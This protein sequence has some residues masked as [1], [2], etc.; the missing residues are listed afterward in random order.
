MT[1][2]DS[3]RSLLVWHVHGSWTESFVAGRHR[4]VVPVNSAQDADGRGLA[5]RNWPRAQEVPVEALHDEDIDL[6]ILQRPQELDL[7]ERWLG[8][9]PG[10]DVPAVYVE[11]NAPRPLPVDSTHPVAARSDIPVVHVTDFNRLMWDS[12]AAPTRVITHGIADPG[13]LY[14][15]DV[16]AAASMINE[17]LRRWRTVGTDVLIE[18]GAHVP[19][20]VWGID[21]LELGRR[22]LRGVRP[23]GDVPTRRLLRQVARR[24]VYLHTARWTSLGMSL[25][26]AMYLGLP[27]VAVASTMAPLVV[28]AEAGLVSADVGTLANSIRRFVSDRAA[29]TL[30]G[31]AA[32]EYAIAH[33]S[34][35]RF[36]AE[37]GEVIEQ[38]CA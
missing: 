20:D 14:T 21:T 29:A 3:A 13:Y 19:I 1:V 2:G 11:H 17:P 16:A 26:E 8:R 4:Y 28:P 6:V 12:G 30:A 9:R 33:F 37:W 38:Q 25:V 34:L 36:L 7:A 15:G 10:V 31:K 35:D 32:R 5:G 23:K 24:R 27:V 18:L 22:P